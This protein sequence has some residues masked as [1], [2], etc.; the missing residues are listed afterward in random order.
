MTVSELIEKLRAYPGDVRV[1]AVGW[2]TGADDIEVREI[3][4]RPD[5][6]EETWMGPHEVDD[7]G[8]ERA[9]LIGDKRRWQRVAL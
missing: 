8:P 2:E 7:A 1:V 9:V 4:L 3:R 6:N 5:V